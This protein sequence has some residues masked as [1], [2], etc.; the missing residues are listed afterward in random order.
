MTL[1]KIA[2]LAGISVSSVS[3]AFSESKEISEET[4]ARV[5]RISKELGCFDKYYKAP[6]KQPLIAIMIPEIDSECYGIYASIFEHELNRRGADTVVA[7]TRFDKDREARLFRE[8]AYRMK[9]DG[10]ILFGSAE[11]I[12]NPD[13]IPLAVLASKS[14]SSD[15]NADVILSDLYPHIRS[16]ISTVKDYGHTEVAFFGE[17]LTVGKLNSFKRAMRSIGLP[18]REKYMLTS[19]KRFADAGADCM[20]RLL[21]SGDPPTVIV[22]AYDQIAYGAMKYAREHGYKIPEDISFIGMDDI[23]SDP[24]FDVPLSSVH[25]GYEQICGAVC[26]LLFAR[27]ENRHYR[28][29]EPVTLPAHVNIRESLYKLNQ[30]ERK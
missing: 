10:I 27:M 8:L 17:P 22:A 7:C 20:R 13:E 21:E 6:R 14:P 18:L 15:A 30:V 16:I 23:T 1:R 11:N 2:E 5:F 12:K 19:D 4:K 3:K 25:I 29:R 28:L 26:D 9:V 24:Y